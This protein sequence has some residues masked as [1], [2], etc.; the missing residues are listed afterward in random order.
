M[1][2][3]QK[4]KALQP[5]IRAKPKWNKSER[6]A[7]QYLTYESYTYVARLNEVDP[8]TVHRLVNNLI[9]SLD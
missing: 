3:I 2:T 6:Y 4:L 9:K 7:M 8:S 1:T 5:T